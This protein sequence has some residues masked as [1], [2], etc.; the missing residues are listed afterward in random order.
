MD[1]ND[2]QAIQDAILLGTFLGLINIIISN[3]YSKE[4]FTQ[5]GISLCELSYVELQ[6][7][8]K[9][10]KNY[11]NFFQKAFLASFIGV[12]EGFMSEEIFIERI[13]FGCEYEKDIYF[14]SY[15]RSKMKFENCVVDFEGMSE[16]YKNSYK[17]T[18]YFYE[19]ILKI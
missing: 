4:K 11:R 6:K 7:T 14:G 15:D 17:S 2:K 5:Q 10:F 12:S 1:F 16:M 13:Y 18:N 19:N 8:E 9:K 3:S